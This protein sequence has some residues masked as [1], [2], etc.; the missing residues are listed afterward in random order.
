[1]QV[2]QAD[3]SWRFVCQLFINTTHDEVKFWCLQVEF[4]TFLNHL[5]DYIH[6]RS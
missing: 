1:M 3:H 5:D 2:K 4:A 6:T